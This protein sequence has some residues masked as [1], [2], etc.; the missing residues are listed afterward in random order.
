MVSETSGVLNNLSTILNG[1]DYLGKDAVLD[2]SEKFQSNTSSRCFQT[3]GEVFSS[4]WLNRGTLIGVFDL[5]I[6]F[7]TDY[8]S[9]PC[10]ELRIYRRDADASDAETE[11]P[12]SPIE[13]TY[14]VYSSNNTG[15]VISGYFSSKYEYMLVLVLTDSFNGT[16]FDLDYVQ[17]IKKQDKNLSWS[18][19]DPIGYFPIA[20]MDPDTVFTQETL[21]SGS[22]FVPYSAG[23]AGKADITFT[24]KFVAEPDV[25]FTPQNQGYIPFHYGW[26]QDDDGL[27]TGITVKVIDPMTNW[28]SGGIAVSWMA[29]GIQMLPIF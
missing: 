18:G 1:R 13:I 15:E 7:D 23:S 3:G 28:N 29:K 24:T 16:Y 21:D 22:V 5:A 17:L 25:I 26:I 10:C 11:M 2:Y 27:Y 8:T 9:D 12:I 14:D 4:G 20:S 6:V 19:E